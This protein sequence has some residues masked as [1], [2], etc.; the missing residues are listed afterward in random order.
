[1]TRPEEVIAVVAGWVERRFA[2]I[3]QGP[4]GD[5]GDPGRDGA[6]GKPGSMGLRGPEGKRG[7]KG[8]DGADGKDGADG[9]DGAKG[10]R[11]LPG[12]AG[13]SSPGAVPQRVRVIATGIDAKVREIEFDGA[14]GTLEGARAVLSGFGGGSGV[15]Q[16][17]TVDL[18]TADIATLNS[19]PV[20]VIPTPGAG[21]TI[22]FAGLPTLQYLAG[23]EPLA[24]GSRWFLVF[25]GG[26]EVDEGLFGMANGMAGDGLIS[27]AGPLFP[28]HLANENV[29]PSQAWWELPPQAATEDK[30]VMLAASGDFSVSGSILT[31][32]IFDA[33]VLYAVNDTI[34]LVNDY[35][36]TPAV[37]VVDS[38]G[39][40]G[41][42]LTYHLT[43]NGTGYIVSAYSQDLTSGIGSGFILTVDTITPL[44]DGTARLTVLYY[45]MDLL[46]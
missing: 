33:G 5:K 26:S 17:V 11:G 42:V 37:L 14:T 7:E 38:V 46:T 43:D 22:G 15:V 32:S 30:S 3:T 20:E 40:G 13:A 31:S 25:D 39:G 44:S 27:Y 4:K 35:A 8:A 16:S 36:A 28:I 23:S 41:E 34:T 18:S 1:M 19:V 12:Q 45:V 10:E 9:Q 6:D 29:E 21:K 24:G 2:D